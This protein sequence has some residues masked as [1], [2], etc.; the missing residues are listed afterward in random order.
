MMG[1]LQE[2]GRGK[3]EAT[4]EGHSDWV[5]CLAAVEKEGGQPLLVSGSRDKSLRLWGLGDD[6]RW[7][8]AGVLSGSDSGLHEDVLA[9]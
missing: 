6:A 1:A 5:L 4:L 3:V 7:E 9:Q 8:C 2:K